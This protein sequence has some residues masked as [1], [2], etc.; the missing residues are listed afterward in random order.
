MVLVQIV[1]EEGIMN[2]RAYRLLSSGEGGESSVWNVFSQ[3]LLPLV[4][5]LAFVAVLQLKR[6]DQIINEADAHIALVEQSS[7]RKATAAGWR[8]WRI[9]TG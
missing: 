9:G 3:I 2:R 8:C 6:Y 5:I 4:F 7:T 1:V